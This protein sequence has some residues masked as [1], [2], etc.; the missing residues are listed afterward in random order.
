MDVVIMGGSA[1]STPGLWAYLVNEA[2][3]RDLRIRLAGR[4]RR[5]LEAVR[6]ACL[7]LARPG[8][9]RLE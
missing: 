1:Q 2:R 6:R 9:N 5:R 8:A 3:L 4:D 7:L